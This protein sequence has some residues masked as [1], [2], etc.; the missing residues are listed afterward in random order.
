MGLKSNQANIEMW[1]TE[2]YGGPKQYTDFPINK[3][4]AFAV[5]PLLFN[6]QSRGTVQL[7]SK[8]PFQN[9]LVDHNY[10]DND[11]DLLVLAEGCRLANEIVMQGSGTKNVVK[12]SWPPDLS[13]HTNSSREDWIPYVK[14]YATTCK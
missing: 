2:L 7:L 5:C 6:A 8:D 14:K 10:L 4:H 11:L 13:H 12:G 9:P 1:N 3:Q